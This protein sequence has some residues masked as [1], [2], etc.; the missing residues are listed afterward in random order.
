MKINRFFTDRQYGF[1]SG[2][3]TSLQLL[4]VL[5]KW[6]EALKNGKYID[7]N[8]MDYMKAFNTVPHKRLM[9][10]LRAYGTELSV[11]N[12]VDSFLSERIQ[13]VSINNKTSSWSKVTS[14]IPQR[15][16]CLGLFFCNFHK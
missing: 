2:R 10:K 14:G 12:W 13:H 15:D 6:L 1:I 3:S 9:N 7:V 5:D 11:L 16:L 8:Y 4:N